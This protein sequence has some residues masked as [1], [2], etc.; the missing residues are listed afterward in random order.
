[1]L[2]F[3]SSQYRLTGL[4]YRLIGSGGI[5]VSQRIPPTQV[6]AALNRT[7]MTHEQERRQSSS[8]SS[9]LATSGFSSLRMST[10]TGLEPVSFTIGSG[11]ADTTASFVHP[12]VDYITNLF[13]HLEKVKL[14]PPMPRIMIFPGYVRSAHT[15]EEASELFPVESIPSMGAP[16]SEE[17]VCKTW[18]SEPIPFQLPDTKIFS[19]EVVAVVCQQFLFI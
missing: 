14:K 19:Q 5:R 17:K 3:T 8:S 7:T 10:S 11:A 18:L 16:S 15:L 1:M 9:S 13:S 6:G 2:P 12:T 4:T